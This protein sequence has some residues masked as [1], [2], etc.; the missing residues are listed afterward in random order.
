MMKAHLIRFTMRYCLAA[1]LCGLC[2]CHDEVEQTI[3]LP[4]P[5]ENTELQD[6]YH[7][8]TRTKPYPKAGNELYLNPPPLLVPQSMKTGERLQFELSQDSNFGSDGTLRS[9]AVEWCMYNPHRKLQTGT[10]YWRFR[11]TDAT[12]MPQGEWSTA[13]SFEV[14]DETPVFTTPG[15]DDFY[16]NASRSYPRLFC[17]LDP[18]LADARRNVESHPEYK[19]LTYRA[20]SALKADFGTGNPHEQAASLKVHIRSL[21]DAYHLTLKYTYLEGMHR[22]L[23]LL[24]A[25]PVSDRL[26]LYTDNF[27]SSDI[28]VCY[29]ML[30]DQLQD[31]MS[32]DERLATEDVMMR[33][34][35]KY[36]KDQCGASENHIFDNHFWQQN[37]RILFQCAF[38]LYDHPQYAGEVLPILE[39]YYELWT[40]RAPASGFNRDGMWHNGTYYLTANITTLY[41]M[42]MLYSYVARKDFLQHPWFHCAGQ[43]LAYTCPPHSRNSGFGDGS[44]SHAEPPRIYAAFADF[45]ARELGDPYAGWYASE[46]GDMVGKDLE[47]RLYRMCATRSYD[48][49]L[50]AN[51]RKMLWYR[52]AGEVVMHSNLTDTD[53]DVNLSFRSSTFGSGSHTTSCQNA[54]NLLYKGRDVYRSSGY[55]QDFD[56]AHNLMSYRHS[57][58][59]NTLLVNGIGQPYSTR[60]YGN[61]MRALE[62]AHITYCLGDASKA[63]NGISDDPMWLK[64]FDAAGIEQTPENGFGET[65]L[66]KYRRHVWM[67]HPEGIVLVYDEL[68]AAEPVTYDWLLHSPSQ[69][70]INR[71]ML[72]VN[73]ADKAAG[74]TAV[75]QLFCNDNVQLSVTDRFLV[76]PA[77]AD[78]ATYPNQW[79]VTARIA[80]K[81]RTRLLAV[82]QVN[83]DNTAARIIR[84]NGNVLTVGDWDIEVQLDA[85]QPA[86]VTISHATQPTVFSLGT[87]HPIV[88]KDIYIRQY[89]GSSI[90][91][92]QMEGEEDFSVIEM[93]D[94][95]PASTR[96]TNSSR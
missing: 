12:G 55:Y 26:L 93:T 19:Q 44:E 68:E 72:T 14:K 16:V 33:V 4:M 89:E 90:L 54:F 75:T 53:K 79:H 74:F 2:S 92:D 60:G 38:L 64:A 51:A 87:E 67:L 42:P 9:E 1:S 35:R 86:S 57:R 6:A 43:A 41:Y 66:T 52:D 84:R 25:S 85:S 20:N 46:C 94:Q 49:S 17:H 78:A 32:P 8:K 62:G 31:R 5:S 28:A 7:E 18:Y 96:A 23:K 45:L 47:L 80:G 30:Y 50:P 91:Y 88:D 36:Y 13:Y 21:Y 10:W 22:L 40:A 11:N 27:T 61:V 73:H 56:D 59:H 83:P 34:L 76:P 95:L 63:Y 65:P 82:V 37:M 29:A 77:I 39:Y 3:P 24:I 71:D 15:F 58:A 70:H 69:L 81:A 48:T